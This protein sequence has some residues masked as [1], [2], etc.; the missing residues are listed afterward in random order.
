MTK[1]CS[2]C[3]QFH[4]ALDDQDD[5]KSFLF[6]NC[7]FKRGYSNNSLNNEI[8]YILFG[9]KQRVHGKVIFNM[10]NRI[11]SLNILSGAHS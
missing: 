5:A 11:N 4:P 1:Y 10:L 8:Y 7:N 3:K 6:H 9:I 2:E